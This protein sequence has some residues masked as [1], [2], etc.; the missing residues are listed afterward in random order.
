MLAEMIKAVIKKTV[1]VDY[2][3]LRLPAAVLARVDSVK[4]LDAYEIGGLIFYDDG[5]GKS[6]QGHAEAY[7]YQYKITVLDR[8]GNPDEAFPPL[9]EIKSRAGSLPRRRTET[10]RCVPLWTASIKILRWKL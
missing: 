4:K 8:F 3:Y 6:C 10:R 1:A 2:P 9:P 7:W 5:E